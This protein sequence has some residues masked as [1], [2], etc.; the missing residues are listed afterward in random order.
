ML[1]PCSEQL[2][3]SV[4]HPAV[5][6]RVV[7]AGFSC[8]ALRS[9][10][11]CKTTQGPSAAKPCPQRAGKGC[12]PAP[13]HEEAQREGHTRGAQQGP[14]TS[15]PSPRFIQEGRVCMWGCCQVQ[16]NEN[17]LPLKPV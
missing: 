5:L 2:S 16:G 1:E 7:H 6:L 12:G 15:F 11:R 13:A 8:G 4:S 9:Q 10:G 14:H 3:S 17:H